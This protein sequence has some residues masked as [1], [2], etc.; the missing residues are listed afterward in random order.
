MPL[1]ARSSFYSIYSSLNTE[2]HDIADQNWTKQEVIL[3]YCGKTELH[4]LMLVS[5]FEAQCDTWTI[6]QW[7]ISYVFPIFL[8]FTE[9]NVQYEQN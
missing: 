5:F 2:E 9:L 4:T 1:L 8:I 7:T 3:G 6:G